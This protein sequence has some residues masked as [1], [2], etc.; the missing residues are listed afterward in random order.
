VSE[1]SG[2]VF[3]GKP[4]RLAAAVQ[5]DAHLRVSQQI[6]HRPPDARRRSAFDAFDFFRV[7]ELNDVGRV[8]GERGISVLITRQ[9]GYHSA[10]LSEYR[11]D[12]TVPYAGSAPPEYASSASR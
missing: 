4:Q 5:L 8:M 3:A 2:I 1:R 10:S 12:H 9:C 7:V 6:P 11:I